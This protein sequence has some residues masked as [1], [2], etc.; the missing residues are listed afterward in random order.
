LTI[1]ILS[2]FILKEKFTVNIL[3][4]SMLCLLGIMVILR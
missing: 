3:I 4:G 2:V 1:L